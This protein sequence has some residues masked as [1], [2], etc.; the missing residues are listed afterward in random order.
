M[1]SGEMAFF[2]RPSSSAVR[3]V[4]P[5]GKEQ[6]PVGTKPS[7]RK[8][9]TQRQCRNILIYGSCKFQDKGCI[10][11]HPSRDIPSPA[12]PESPVPAPALPAQSVNAPVFVPKTPIPHPASPAPVASQ[13]YQSQSSSSSSSGAIDPTAAAAELRDD[14]DPVV[15]ANANAVAAVAAVTPAKEFIPFE[16]YG[17]AESMPV[18]E[19]SMMSPY[20]NPYAA[21]DQA[22]MLEY[23]AQGADLFYSTSPSF[24]RQPLQY[25]LYTQPRP[26]DL[27]PRFFVPDD[28]REELQQRAENIHTAPA[29]GLGLPEE[30]QGYHSLIPLEPVTGERRKFG[31]WY[32]AV[33]RATKASDGLPYVLRRIENFRLKDVEA[34]S[35]ILAWRRIQHPNIISVREAFT[36][37][38]FGDASLVV[39]YDYHPNSTTLSEVHVRSKQPQATSGRG[40][41]SQD[42]IP[43]QN[44]LSYIV[45]IASAV[46][47]V[48]DA[49]LSLRIIDATKILITGKNRVRVGS[50]GVVDVLMYEAH[51]DMA[52]LQQED[53]TMFGKLILAL[54]CHHPGAPYNP[55]KALEQINRYYS[56][57]VKQIALFLM[58]K[59]NVPQG[60]KAIDQIV[61]MLSRQSIKKVEEAHSAVDRLEAG[62]M[63]E[64][65]N[66]R[67]VRLLCKFGFIN[68]RP[69]FALDPRWSETGDRYIIKLF[70]DYVF[71]QVDEHGRPVVNLSHVLTCLNKLDAGTD[72]RIMLVSRDE[73]SCLV[74]T[75]KE[76]KS[77]IESAF[78]CVYSKVFESEHKAD[79]LL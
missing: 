27:Q 75:Y 29:P 70:R 47:A 56:V 32:S 12:P 64:L 57:E 68:E 3:I 26:E 14:N 8:D 44:L 72:E 40:S 62:L 28:I 53:L 17:M 11:S 50:C 16:P 35:T 66:G 24:V 6:E 48:H 60:K 43:E 69:E 30:L 78:K 23:D 61:D 25:H 36:T 46:K 51:Q 55:Q 67:L 79:F 9:S 15:A 4:A 2:A 74:V 18:P 37:S 31:N 13:Y 21:Q 58:G 59:P 38:A 76:V 65:E 19:G 39:V 34:F 10:Y 77:C 52:S 20:A 45:Q 42:R 33:Y 41:R 63:S 49:G 7:P 22:Q 54:C 5:S 1:A 73:Q 71:H